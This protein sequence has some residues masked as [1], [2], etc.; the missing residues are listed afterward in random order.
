MP[1]PF[2]QTITQ[3]EFN[4]G[5]FGGVA[6]QTWFRFITATEIMLGS[7]TNKGGTFLPDAVLYQSDG[8]TVI[9][10]INSTATHCHSW[11]FYVP[12]GTYYVKITRHGGG[13]SNFDF[14]S[15]FDTRPILSSVTAGDII[16]NDDTEGL[17]AVVMSTSGVVNGFL[18]NI[19]SGEIADALPQG[20][21]LWH[22]KFGLQVI[23]QVSAFNSTPTYIDSLDVGVT[24][25][26]FPRICNDG[27]IFYVFNTIDQNLFT[28][29]GTGVLT[30]PID[31]VA[32]TPTNMGGMGISRDGTILY[33]AQ[34][35]GFGSGSIERWEIGS[36]ALSDLYTIPGFDILNDLVSRSAEGQP[37]DMIVLADDS[38]VT[39]WLDDSL[40]TYFVLHI[41][42]NGTLINS[43]E[44]DSSLLV[45]HIHYFDDSSQ[46]VR[47]WVF[48][49]PFL[50]LGR[51]I[52]LKLSD[53]SFETSFDTDLFSEGVS[54]V[55][56]SPNIW[57]PAASCAMVTY[58]Y[59]NVA[60]PATG[61]G[62]IY[63]I[64]PGKRNDTIWDED[65]L[66]THD[67]K[68]P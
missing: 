46:F 43:I 4:G 13:A 23:D 31:F 42:Q 6:N 35:T 61:T 57:G 41:A 58:L 66:G 67:V 7:F 51:Y 20:Q 40:N 36:G 10:T 30:G 37:G 65:F 27:T 1:F 56:D 14:T 28:A 48:R 59:G 33:F 8:S 50:T 39:W 60:P 29:T 53:G 21:Q 9:Q 68:I 11:H 47:L 5:T 24:G 34:V 2:S 18:T 32:T 17:P 12:A 19:P 15:N 44:L 45:D 49:D 3:A 52:Q 22:D 25:S 64:V 38:V 55:D 63:K 54:L 16:V 62:G 26:L